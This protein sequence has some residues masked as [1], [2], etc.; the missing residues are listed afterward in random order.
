MPLTRTHRRTVRKLDARAKALLDRGGEEALLGSL[1]DMMLAFKP[2]L[3]AAVPGELDQLCSAYPHF[4]QFAHLLTYFAEAIGSG[5][6]DAEL[7]RK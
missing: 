6:F 2:V 3:E 1:H 4:G 5:A 7:G